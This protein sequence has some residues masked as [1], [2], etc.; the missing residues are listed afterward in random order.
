V[1]RYLVCVVPLCV[2]KGGWSFF[3]IAEVLVDSVAE[4]VWAVM[5]SVDVDDG[6]ENPSVEDVNEPCLEEETEVGGLRV[7]VVSDVQ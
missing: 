2:L 5:K 3:A 1:T 7:F 4:I 6:V